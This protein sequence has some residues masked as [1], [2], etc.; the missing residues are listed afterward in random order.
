MKMAV[1]WVVALCRLEKVYRRFRAIRGIALILEA[2][3][4]SETSVNFY[5]TTRLNNTEDSH[6]HPNFLSFSASQNLHCT[7]CVF[8]LTTKKLSCYM[9]WWCM[10]GEEV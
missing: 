5:Q 2:A 6:L 10:G 7:R 4:T 9:P 1:F 3:C 8:A